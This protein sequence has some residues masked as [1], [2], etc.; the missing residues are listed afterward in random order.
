M[1][2]V[3]ERRTPFAPRD[4]GNKSK[5]MLIRVNYEFPDR[6]EV[7]YLERAPREGST[8]LH[9]GVRWHVETVDLDTTGDYV[10]RLTPVRRRSAEASGSRR[11]RGVL[12]TR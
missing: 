9:D 8:F 6:S 7:R 5:N 1:N 10:V 11:R 2:E 3:M 4:R 12:L